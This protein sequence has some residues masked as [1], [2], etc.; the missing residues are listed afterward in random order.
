MAVSEVEM[1]KEGVLIG[2]A[3][4]DEQLRDTP[5]ATPG[6]EFTGDEFRPVVDLQSIRFTIELD[7]ALKHT[8]DTC[9][10]DARAGLS[11]FTG[12]KR[13][14]SPATNR[15]D[16]CSGERIELLRRCAMQ[17]SSKSALLLG[18]AS[19]FA[20]GLSLLS[21][22][23]LLPSVAHAAVTN[24]IQH[25]RSALS[26]E[27][28]K[29]LSLLERNVVSGGP[30]KDGIPAIDKPQYTTAAAA[31]TWLL[32]HDIVFGLEH[33]GFVA[34]YPQRVL[35]WHE[36]VNDRL[37]EQPVS[38]TY[39][40]LTGTAIGFF[41]HIGAASTTLGVSG[42]LVNSNLV[43]YDRASDSYW[44][45]I[46][47]TAIAGPAKGTA[48]KEFPLTWT[49]WERWKRKHPDTR[50]LS[51]ETGFFRN[52]GRGG[53]PYGSYLEDHKGYYADEGLLLFNPIHHDGRLRSKAIVVGM[54]DA[55]GNALAVEKDALRQSKTTDATLGG[56]PVVV[57]YDAALD[58]HHAEY[59][60]TGE[61]LNAFDAMWFAWVAFY[62]DTQLVR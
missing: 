28:E 46:L 33:D 40:P 58:A 56:R 9:A 31:D 53:D 26:A 7:Q 24:D 4:L 25:L 45:Q 12:C 20:I 22:S 17:L 34:A 35:V 19:L 37:K 38:V 21:G 13:S 57:R 30:P 60:D 32:P 23:N 16:G 41:G 15:L 44:P 6:C 50:V 49:T 42:K 61:R 36:I 27:Q 3:G 2:F 48:L 43:M 18:T 55:Q 8:D 52:Y 51:R 47:G 5:F 39:C 59:T 29:Y 10:W 14:A 62:P 54:R 1:L 11:L